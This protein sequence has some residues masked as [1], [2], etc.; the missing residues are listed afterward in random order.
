MNKGR[1]NLVPSLTRN[2]GFRVKGVVLFLLALLLLTWGISYVSLRQS[3]DQ[4]SLLSEGALPS[5]AATLNLSLMLE[6]VIQNAERLSNADNQAERRV[7]YAQTTEAINISTDFFSSHATFA[8][9]RGLGEILATLSTT[10]DDLNGIIGEKLDAESLAIE[11]RQSI[12]N[13]LAGSNYVSSA[14][15]D[16]MASWSANFQQSLLRMTGLTTDLNARTLRRDITA[17]RRALVRLQ[18]ASRTLPPSAQTQAQA[19]LSD[20]T[21]LLT[22]EEGLFKAL[23][24]HSQLELRAKALAR[25]MR[26]ITAEMV[27]ELNAL[28]SGEIDE[29]QLSTNSLIE[30]SE[31]RLNWLVLTVVVA[32]S[33]AF[34]SFLYIDRSVI[35]RLNRLKVAVNDHARGT[36]TD[37]PVTG[38][39]EITEI[40]RAVAYFVDEMDRRQRRLMVAKN[41][42]EEAAKAK[43]SFLAMMSHEI[44]SPMNGIISVAEILSRADMDDEHQ[45]L[46]GVINQSAE[47]LLTIINDI[48]DFSKIEAGKLEISPFD[49]N[50]ADLVQSSVNLLAS[51]FDRKNLT[52]DI[53]IDRKLP[54]HVHGDGNRLRQILFNLLSNAAK[55]TQE[56]GVTVHAFPHEATDHEA[57][58]GGM[59]GISLAITDTGIGMSPEYLDRLFQPFEQADSSTARK[60]GGTGLGLSICKQLTTLM[61]GD[62]LVESAV[63]AGTSFTVTLPFSPAEAPAAQVPPQ[64]TP[65]KASM[66]RAEVSSRRILVVEDNPINQM[67]I[68]KIL[69]ELSCTFDMAGDGLEALD[70]LKQDRFD[71][72]LTDLRMPNMDGFTMTQEIRKQENAPHERLP[73][74]AIS[75]DA[76]DEARERSKHSGID[77]FIAKPVKIEEVKACLDT[78]IPLEECA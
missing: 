52:I 62:M 2:L 56:G 5:L 10:A 30:R 71:L 38:Q 12:T 74:I 72:V 70:K 14:Q 69:Q 61:G 50:L 34:L 54:S 22:S 59:P 47:M 45:R 60:Y 8:S 64:K 41:K 17:I 68:G 19:L 77:A 65:G 7:T 27:R 33:I 20:L 18:R 25:Q 11:K 6:E 24:S 15:T 46:V 55:F 78:Y 13:W 63:G 23:Q 57:S 39:D 53:E 66:R 3:T 4:V 51:E 44:R 16:G 21:P 26:L 9:E 73:I 76:M 28:S 1:K 75:A 42:A 43:S 29:A 58:D 40:S 31:S 49:F 35:Q 32:A 67:V 37:I 36:Q 48:L